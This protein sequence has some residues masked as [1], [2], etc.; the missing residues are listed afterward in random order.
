[1]SKTVRIVELLRTQAWAIQ[2]G[3]LESIYS[4]AIRQDDVKALAAQTGK[5]LDNTHAVELRDGVA[6]LSVFG[7]LFPR[8]NLF[9][10][11][12]GAT[13]ID[14]LALDFNKALKNDSVSAIVLNFDSPGGVT[15]HI[16][17]MAGMINNANKPVI[18]YISGNAGSAAYYL[19][20]A[21]NEVVVDATAP[22]GGIGVVT[23]LVKNKNDETIEFISSNAPD[24]RPDINTE[25]GRAVI[26][27]HIDA[28]ES[29]FIDSV[30]Q[31]RR[32]NQED[33][34]A[35]RGGLFV[36]QGAVDAGLADR[37]GSLESVISELQTNQT[38]TA[39]TM[40][41]AQ[42]KAEHPSIHQTAFDLGAQSVQV[43][44][45][46]FTTETITAEAVTAERERMKDIIGCEEAKGRESLAKHIAFDTKMPVGDAKKILLSTPQSNRKAGKSQFELAMLAQGNPDILPDY[47][48]IVEGDPAYAIINAGKKAG[49]SF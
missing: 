3:W 21:A 22:V 25:Q 44:T 47:D 11:I 41:I 30:S 40:K 43:K 10:Q 4:L 16:N 12:L 6:V 36:G 7:P 8:A 2:D 24:K 13:S 9:A 18:A 38:S 14:R 34:I 23:R 29:V 39:I 20:S 49:I 42:F 46:Q 32:L 33:I 28:M 27:N 1:M 19:A 15:T 37:L 5:P 31:F 35:L 17:E 45:D 48:G 26:Q